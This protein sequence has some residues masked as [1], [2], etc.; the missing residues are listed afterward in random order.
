MNWTRTPP[1]KPGAYWWRRNHEQPFK[2]LV[3]LW[4]NGQVFG[5]LPIGVSWDEHEITIPIIAKDIG[6]E[7][8]GPLV[9]VEEVRKAWDECAAYTVMQSGYPA[10]LISRARHVVEGEE[11]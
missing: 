5:D 3:L 7:W 9:P 1:T 11:V 8:C 2:N 6:G 10:W 4:A